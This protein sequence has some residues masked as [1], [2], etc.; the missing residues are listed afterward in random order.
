[1][2]RDVR[3]GGPKS[4]Q[5][6]VPRIPFKELRERAKALTL[7]ADPRL[8]V[9]NKPPGLASQAGRGLSED[10]NSIMQGQ[11]RD[12]E[13]PV[14]LVHRLDRE[15]SG[16]MVMARTSAEAARLSGLF[17]GR[18]VAKGY[19][20]LV[21]GDFG[22]VPQ[23]IDQPLKPMKSARAALMQVAEAKDIDA[24][25]A[26]TQATLIAS[27]ASASLVLALPETGRMHQIRV[28]LAHIGHPLLGDHHYG[29]PLAVGAAQVP[30]VMLHAWWLAL[31][32]VQGD[33]QR[34]SAPVPDDFANLCTALGLQLPASDPTAD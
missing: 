22:A 12:K 31:P 24:Q 23:S 15:T 9:V 18:E 6:V 17:A 29:G 33:Y 13:R 28:H 14:R 8:L 34:W 16:I 11:A 30:R 20:A 10:L 2:P 25:A 7:Y 32:D 21:A 3:P 19:L 4:A 27:S 5:G 1:M 26:I